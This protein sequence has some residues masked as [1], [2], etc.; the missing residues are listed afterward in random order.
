M[1]KELKRIKVEYTVR[2]ESLRNLV[3]A[4]FILGQETGLKGMTYEH[5]KAKEYRN[6]LVDLIVNPVLEEE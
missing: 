4:A 3:L 2:Y 5:P 6:N 1:S